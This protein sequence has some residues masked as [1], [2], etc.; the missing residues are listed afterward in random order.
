MKIPFKTKYIIAGILVGQLCIPY[1]A[2][3][4]FLRF[5][6]VKYK[7]SISSQFY[8]RGQYIPLSAEDAPKK[9]EFVVV[10]N[11][12]NI[13]EEQYFTNEGQKI[14]VIYENKKWKFSSS[15]LAW[16]NSLQFIFL[17]SGM[18][19]GV[20]VRLFHKMSRTGQDSMWRLMDYP[21]DNFEKLCLIY[22]VSIFVGNMVFAIISPYLRN[23]L[24]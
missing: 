21:D 13:H 8:E 4:S 7:K 14:T 3:Y 2:T 10:R 16:S 20:F 1:I 22:G 24:F 11:E 17:G 15:S 12:N 9:Y 6:E 19:L 18:V 23:L 5:E